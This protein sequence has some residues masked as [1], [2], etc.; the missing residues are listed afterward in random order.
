VWIVG[1]NATST[2][3]IPFTMHNNGSGWT[4]VT[5]PS[6]SDL[7]RLSSVAVNSGDAWAG[8]QDSSNGYPLTYK[9]L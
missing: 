5:T 3:N 4:R 6:S 8:G 7:L 9:S 2:A 1:Y